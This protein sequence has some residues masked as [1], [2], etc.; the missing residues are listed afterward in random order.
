MAAYTENLNLKKPDETDF[1]DIKDINENMDAVDNAIASNEQRIEEIE[2]NQNSIPYAVCTDDINNDNLTAEIVNGVFELKKGIAIDVRFS[3]ECTCAAYADATLNVNGTGAKQIYVGN[4]HLYNSA[5]QAGAIVRFVY[6]GAYW[7]AQIPVRAERTQLGVVQLTN[8]VFN[9]YGRAAEGSWVADIEKSAKTA[10]NTANNAIPK[11]QIDEAGGVASLDE[12][13][14]VAVERIP[15]DEIKKLLHLPIIVTGHVSI[16][17]DEANIPKA[18]HVDFP[19]DLFTAAP[20]VFV[21]PKTSVPGTKVLG[22]SVTNLTKTG[23]DIYI[24]RTAAEQTGICWLA[25]QV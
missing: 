4:K 8:S 14:K 22:I 17:T 15:V 25:I 24:T 5:W 6:N 12:N 21:N 10:N 20:C 1:V 13:R 2:K 3:H 23:C 19:E 7:V 16:A 9:A 18:Q 11:S